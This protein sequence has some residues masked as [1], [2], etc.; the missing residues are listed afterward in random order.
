MKIK[1]LTTVTSPSNQAGKKGE[2]KDVSERIARLLIKG[3]FAKTVKGKT[4]VDKRTDSQS[5]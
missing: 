4:H 1:Y 3:G 2:T 5:G